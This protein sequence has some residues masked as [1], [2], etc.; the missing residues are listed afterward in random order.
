MKA[1]ESRMSLRILRVFRFHVAVLYPVRLDLIF[2][3]ALS[4]RPINEIYWPERSLDFPFLGILLVSHEVSV[5]DPFARRFDRECRAAPRIVTVHNRVKRKLTFR[6]IWAGFVVRDVDPLQPK[7]L[8]QIR[9][10][11]ANDLQLT[12][13]IQHNF[14]RR[15]YSRNRK[16]ERAQSKPQG[17]PF[18]AIAN[19]HYSNTTNPT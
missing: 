12:K 13:V 7:T 3:T 9:R 2:T 14:G 1:S 6:F 19:H 15:M 16:H 18:K 11:K 17:H 4:F 5:A 10:Y 8:R